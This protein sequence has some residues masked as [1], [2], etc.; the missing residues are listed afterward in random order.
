MKC[1]LKRTNDPCL[2]WLVDH[3]Q[4]LSR[5]NMTLLKCAPEAAKILTMNHRQISAL[6]GKT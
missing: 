1:G 3:K 6:H 4:L 2:R 5:C